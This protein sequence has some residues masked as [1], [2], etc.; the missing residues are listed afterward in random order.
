MKVR[1]ELHVCNEILVL[2]KHLMTV[3][4]KT[5]STITYMY[6]HNTNTGTSNYHVHTCVC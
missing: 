4:I 2:T 6:T 5:C 1:T 3:Q